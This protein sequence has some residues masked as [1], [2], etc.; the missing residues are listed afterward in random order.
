[1]LRVSEGQT[2]T[3]TASTTLAMRN[4][5]KKFGKDGGLNPEERHSQKKISCHKSL[6][7]IFL[8]VL[9]TLAK[10]FGEAENECS[11]TQYK[12]PHSSFSR[13]A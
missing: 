3:S 11:V 7:H 13:T 4:V 5:Q 12:M 10:Q 1:M 2:N 9:E 8:K 6:I